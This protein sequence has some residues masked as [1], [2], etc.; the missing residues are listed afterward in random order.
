VSPRP[1]SANGV[2]LPLGPIAK[3]IGKGNPTLRK[4]KPRTE[5]IESS[6]ESSLDSISRG[7]GYDRRGN[8][9]GFGPRKVEVVFDWAT[10]KAL[11]RFYVDH[12]EEYAWLGHVAGQLIKAKLAD[13]GYLYE[14]SPLEDLETTQHVQLR[15]AAEREK[16]LLVKHVREDWATLSPA[17]K[18]FHLERFPK[19]LA[20]LPRP[21]AEEVAVDRAKKAARWNPLRP[22]AVPNPPE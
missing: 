22:P 7:K 20:D 14:R 1:L 2:A 9:G 6:L 8:P 17:T 15:N 19:E 13:L 4:N 12:A 21:T 18:A 3:P 5:R 11:N 10:L 16:A